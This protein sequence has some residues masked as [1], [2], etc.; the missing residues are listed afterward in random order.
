M[1]GQQQPV[2]HSQT[3]RYFYR[4]PT[5]TT[6]NNTEKIENFFKK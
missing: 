1:R 3:L 6:D 2:K 5:A 4:A